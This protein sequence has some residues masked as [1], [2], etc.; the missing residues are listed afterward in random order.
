MKSVGDI[1]KELGFD[2]NAPEGVKK[3]FIKY[4]IRSSAEYDKIYK[5]ESQPVKKADPPQQLD[6]FYDYQDQ[7]PKTNH[8]QQKP[9]KKAG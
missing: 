9:K 4:L 5:L 1:M 6:L 3:A 7:P 8:L 2:P